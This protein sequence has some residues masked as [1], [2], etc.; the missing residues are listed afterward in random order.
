MTTWLSAI[1]RQSRIV[2]ENIVF[3]TLNERIQLAEIVNSEADEALTQ[4]CFNFS[5]LMETP[6]CRELFYSI[7]PDKKLVAL[8]KL[9]ERYSLTS[10]PSNAFEQC[11]EVL[12]LMHQLFKQGN[13]IVSKCLLGEKLH[14]FFELKDNGQQPSRDLFADIY[15]SAIDELR[16]NTFETVKLSRDYEVS[17]HRLPADSLVE[18][19][20]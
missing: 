20:A 10:K 17:A 16:L 5:E 2:V 4:S 8:L 6:G 3:E 11:Q 19:Y 9:I 18:K 14:Q 1:H 13:S 12:T 15:S 7:V